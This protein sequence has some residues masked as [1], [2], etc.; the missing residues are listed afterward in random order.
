VKPHT[1]PLGE[2]IK[3]IIKI[4]ASFLEKRMGYNKMAAII[5]QRLAER[6]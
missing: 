5:R 3:G 6:M 2:P 4:E 1:L